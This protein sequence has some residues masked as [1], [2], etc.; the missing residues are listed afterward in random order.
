MRVLYVPVGEKVWLD[1]LI[2]SGRGMGAYSGDRFQRGYGLGSIFGALLRSILPVA[3]SV[4]KTVG[5]QALRTG[6][7]VAQDYLQGGDIKE[8][9]KTRGKQ[10]AKQLLAKG[11]QKVM[12]GRGLGVRSRKP[13]KSI[14]RLKMQRKPVKRNKD[15]LGLY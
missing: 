3:K 5:R 8:S 2:Q 1:N 10:G 14:K 7:E 15:A 6:A 12:R 9:I 4:A 13:A 11:V